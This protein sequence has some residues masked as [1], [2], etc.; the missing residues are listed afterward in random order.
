MRLTKFA[1]LSFLLSAGA[2]IIPLA[3]ATAQPAPPPPTQ[4]APPPP[5]QPGPPPA[6]QA[7][8]PP[9]PAAAPPAPPSSAVTHSS[10]NLRAGPGT[11]YTIV[12]L[13]PAGSSVDVNDCKTGWCHVAF[14]GQDGYIIE[15]SIA[16][17]APGAAARRPP[18][19]Y[20]GPGYAGPPPGYNG[21]PPGYYYPPPAYGYGYYYRPYGPYWGWRGYYRRW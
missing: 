10:V 7:A 1:A 8:P 13:I 19:S 15:S 11:S 4:P 9:S 20:A 18:P 6:T 5:A 16:P 12:T 17:G 14:H 2:V 3:R 21:P